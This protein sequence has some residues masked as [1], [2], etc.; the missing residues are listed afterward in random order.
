MKRV[1]VIGGG[2]VGLPLAVEIARAGHTVIVLET[3]TAKVAAVEARRSYIADVPDA[4]LA[5][6]HDTADPEVLQ[7]AEIVVICV[8]TPL[9]KTREPDNS[10]VVDA[11]DTV[12]THVK[13]PCL[14][15]LE[16]TTFPGFTREVMV[17]KLPGIHVAFSPERVDPGNRTYGTRNT[18]KVLGG[19]TPEALDRAISFYQTFIDHVVPVSST[20][21]AEMVKLLENTFRA[22]NIGLVNETAI[23]CHRLGLDVWEVIKA[24]STKPYGFMPFY[25]GP[26]LGGHCIPVDPLYLAWKLK[27]LDYTSRFIGLAD[28]VNGEM[29]AY[30]VSRVAEALNDRKKPLNGSLILVCGVAYKADV[31]DVRE[32]P[33]LAIIELLRKAKAHV[34]YYDS[35]V[36][37]VAGM[38]STDNI[39]YPP[40]YD[41]VIIATAHS[42]I[43][44]KALAARA[45]LVVDCR[46]VVSGPNVVRL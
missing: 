9:T 25:P 18:P 11:L 17:P 34:R 29:P 35:H 23:M 22:V 7:C 5:S 42:E 21:V 39:Y 24:A 31:S 27:T 13:P 30:V 36:P 10:F 14:V 33:A 37:T 41:C 45:V 19:A 38:T 3:D 20:D 16:S 1:V 8:P 40:M 46:N 4:A 28:A 44:Y 15:V 26:G 12:R 32:S 43:D 2:Y 6:L